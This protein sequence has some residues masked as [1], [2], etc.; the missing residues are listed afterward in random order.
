[1]NVKVVSRAP[2]ARR[3]NEGLVVQN[4]TDVADKTFIQ[5]LVRSLAVVYPTVGFADDA[6]A[7]GWRV[8]FGHRKQSPG[9]REG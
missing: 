4:E 7:R 1:M 3:D 2:V 5:D 6:C 9:N 8:G